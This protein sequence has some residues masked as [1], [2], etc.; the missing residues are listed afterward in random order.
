MGQVHTEPLGFGEEEEYTFD[1]PQVIEDIEDVELTDKNFDNFVEY[2][3]AKTFITSNQL[4]Q[5]PSE[6]LGPLGMRIN[7]LVG[8][9]TIAALSVST[10][11]S[12]FGVPISEKELLFKA[13]EESPWMNSLHVHVGSGGMGVKILAAGIR[14]LVDAAKEIN[15]K[16]GR[17]Q[18]TH[19]DIG[20]G[21][22]A[23]YNSDDWGAEAVKF[24]HADSSELSSVVH[25][26]FNLH[27]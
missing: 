12:K 10:S 23:N 7:P 4:D 26:I 17:P 21:L 18:I 11:E 6:S 25:R 14:I 15:V 3:R 9:G 8:K 24:F 16:V 2:E 19:L 22:P 1:S 27:G 13:Y 20:G 5:N